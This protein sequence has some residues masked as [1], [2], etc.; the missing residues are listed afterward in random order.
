MKFFL[1]AAL[2]A[3]AAFSLWTANT[4]EYVSFADFR[5]ALAGVFGSESVTVTELQKTYADAV[6][7]EGKVKIL[8]VPGHDE[9]N[10]GTEYAG[11]REETLNHE[12]GAALAAA[13]AKNPAFEATLLR[14]G[15]GFLPAFEEAFQREK[16]EIRAEVGRKKKIMSDLIAAGAVNRA[17]GVPHNAAALDTALRLYAINGWA[18]AKGYS[19]VL[20]IHFNDYG[21]RR[22]GTAGRYRGFAVYVP[23]AQYSN[24]RASRALGEAI[25]ARLATS[26][27][28]SSLPKEGGGTGLVSDQELIAVGAY[29]T[30]DAA[31][32]LLEYAYI[33][34]PGLHDPAKRAP[35]LRAYAAKTYEGIEA[36]L[37]GDKHGAAALKTSALKP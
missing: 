30:L 32:A 26:F 12:A 4:L 24:A 25:A 9:Q 6:R 7:G 23:E 27:P 13:F 36:F 17:D 21:G 20:H 19:L 8:I 29:N 37:S 10:W 1:I 11:L 35:L 15:E 16:E 18:N 33:Y 5:R 31:A 34:E 14:D 3:V 22:A 28:Q 2:G